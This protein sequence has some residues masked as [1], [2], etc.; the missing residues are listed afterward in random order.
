MTG[1]GFKSDVDHV[2]V[3]ELLTDMSEIEILAELVQ[4]LGLIYRVIIL[5]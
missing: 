3:V 2:M 4:S 1:T 5:E